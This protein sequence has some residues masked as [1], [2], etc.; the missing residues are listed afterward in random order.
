M[1]WPQFWFFTTGMSI[2]ATISLFSLL[3]HLLAIVAL[4]YVFHC[5]YCFQY[6]LFAA[7]MFI[8]PVGQI[9]ENI[10]EQPLQTEKYTL[11]HINP[12]S[13]L[14]QLFVFLAACFRI[15]FMVLDKQCLGESVSS[16]MEVC[17]RRG[18]CPHRTTQR[19]CKISESRFLC[20]D[21]SGFPPMPWFSNQ[22]L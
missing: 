15:C 18:Q 9:E 17:P 21:C 11:Y 20:N 13:K 8:V 16:P 12:T 19:A 14:L 1:I 7:S 2:L 5:V 10:K 22:S 4:C 3:H 6:S